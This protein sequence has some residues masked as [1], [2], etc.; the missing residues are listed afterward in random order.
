MS[1][2]VPVGTSQLS[3]A[4]LSDGES[5][6]SADV[7]KELSVLSSPRRESAATL[8]DTS[9]L[10]PA[11]GSK[12]GGRGLKTSLELVAARTKLER[13]RSYR[14]GARLAMLHWI[15]MWTWRLNKLYTK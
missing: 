10:L 14:K 1:T 6:L 15:A 8:R 5:R 7:V 13:G 4:P 11:N 9:P 3:S 12:D 2:S